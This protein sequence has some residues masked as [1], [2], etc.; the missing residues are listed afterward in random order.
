MWL[1]DWIDNPFWV[2]AIGIGVGAVLAN[3][4]P[5]VKRDL[6]GGSE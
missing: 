2:M 4:A 6:E 5:M 3:T 1:T